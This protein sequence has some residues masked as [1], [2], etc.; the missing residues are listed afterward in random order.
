MDSKLLEEEILRLSRTFTP[1]WKF[2]RDNPDMGSAIAMIFAEHTADTINRYIREKG[3]YR[4]GILKILELKP[5]PAQASHAVA[6]IR[7]VKVQG[8]INLPAGTRF[9]AKDEEGDESIIFETEHPIHVTDSKLTAIAA[10]SQKAGNADM[11]YDETGE[12]LKGPVDFFPGR[13]KGSYTNE[14]HIWHPYIFDGRSG[15]VLIELSRGRLP[16]GQPPAAAE[17]SAARGP[18][19]QEIVLSRKECEPAKEWWEDIALS[20][21]CKDAAPDFIFNGYRELDENMVLPFGEE[22]TVYSE[23]WFGQDEIFKMGGADIAM[24]FTLETE[25]LRYKDRSS[26][27]GKL[28]VIK[29]APRPLTVQKPAKVYVEEIRLEYYN[30]NGFKRI[31]T[32]E[33]IRRIFHRDGSREVRIEFECPG[34]WE[35]LEIGGKNARFLRMQAVKASDC[36][37]RPAVHHYP[38]MTDIRFDCRYCARINEG[39]RIYRK[40]GARITEITEELMEH[41]PF[42]LFPEFPYTKEQMLLGFDKKFLHGPVSIYLITEGRKDTAKIR[43]HFEYL[44]PEGFKPLDVTDHTNGLSGSGMLIFVP[45]HDMEKGEIE[46]VCAYWIRMAKAGGPAEENGPRVNR[47]YLNG[48]QVVN[49]ERFPVQEYFLDTVNPGMT[50]PAEAENILDVRVMASE[51][52]GCLTEWK[53]MKSF[54]NSTSEDRHY[55]LDRQQGRIQFGD[56][57][58]GRIPG[59]TDGLTFSLEVSGCKGEAG[60]VRE[61]AIEGTV[62][63]IQGLSEVTNPLPAFGGWNQEPEENLYRRADMVLKNGNIL[64]S[65]KDYVEEILAF[66]DQIDEAL[67]RLE[68]GKMKIYILMKDMCRSKKS[69]MVLFGKL[70]KHLLEKCQPRYNQ[71]NLEILE[72]VFIT[73]SLDIWIHPKEGCMSLQDNQRILDGLHDFLSPFRMGKGK[74]AI[75]SIPDEEQIRGQV[76]K[77]SFPHKVMCAGVLASYE[78]E[79]GHHKTSL[80]SIPRG[81]KAVCINGEHHIHFG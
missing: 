67:L 66:S 7:T 69:V 10:I 3:R 24:S 23:C 80:P 40:L 31:Q 29:R 51:K 62:S 27:E 32:S 41:R 56:G 76:K 47:I 64:V 46:G 33:D 37:I 68:D 44:G 59:C 4:E 9:W 36:Y 20:Y 60:N 54:R 15:E 61:G 65:E 28:K 18:G 75:G 39:M 1:E 53:E 81:L 34:D 22:I 38:V 43:L 5:M 17:L 30:G 77:L 19:M 73:L 63:Y 57:K 42:C 72:P 14:F 12:G 11:I 70:R 13:M 52:D 74:T 48:V 26:E 71:D 78:D 2:I 50:F 58:K 8:G 6:A 49:R 45:P 21:E 35:P 16:G 55:V 79:K 25:F